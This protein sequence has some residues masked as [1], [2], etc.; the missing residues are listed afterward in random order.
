MPYLDHWE[1][2]VYAREGF[3]AKQ[4][5][6]MLMPKETRLGITVTGILAFIIVLECN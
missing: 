5:E 3:S 4:K 1:K 2:S 6:M